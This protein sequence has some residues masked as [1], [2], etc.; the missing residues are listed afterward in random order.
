[1]ET[2]LEEGQEALYYLHLLGIGIGQRLALPRPWGLPWPLT[3][4]LLL[5]GKAKLEPQQ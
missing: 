1:V 3:A 2:G 4:A 5:C